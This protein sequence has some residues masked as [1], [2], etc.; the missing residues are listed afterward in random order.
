M[1]KAKSD[2]IRKHADAAI[3]ALAMEVAAAAA[4]EPD[5]EKQRRLTDQA[6][7]LFQRAH[8]REGGR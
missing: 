4:R 2:T 6:L 3:L 8:G 1:V 7:R 5:R